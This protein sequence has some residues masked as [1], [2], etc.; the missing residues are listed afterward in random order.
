MYMIRA[1]IRVFSLH[2]SITIQY[3]KNAKKVEITNVPYVAL[4]FQRLKHLLGH[5]F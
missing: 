4:L 2:T 3:S 5:F 1:M